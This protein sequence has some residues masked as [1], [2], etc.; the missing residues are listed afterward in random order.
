MPLIVEQKISS[1]KTKDLISSF[2]KILGED[3]FEVA[4]KKKEI[5]SGKGKLR[6]RK[7]KR[8]AGLLLVLGNKE[9]LK[10]KLVD[11][12]NAERLNITDLANGGVGRLTIYTEEAIKNLGERIK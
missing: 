3:L 4:L 10:T 2:K 6:G 5:R 1:L 8:N 11:V 12:V 9:K 7:Y